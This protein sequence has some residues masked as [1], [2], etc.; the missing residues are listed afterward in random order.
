MSTITITSTA[1][2][3]IGAITQAD[4]PATLTIDLVTPGPAGPAGPAGPIGP[5]GPQ[6]DPGVGVPSG[7]SEGQILSKVDATD[8][9]TTWIDNY[10]TELRI[11]ARNETGAT[12]SKGTVVYING[13][14]GNKPTLAKALATGDA[15]SA[16]TLGLV[17]ADI[18]NNQNGEVTVRGLLIGVDTSAYAAG[19]Q[20]YLSGTTAG[21]FTSTKP[22]A[23]IHIVYV[24]IVSR[25]HANQGQIE[26]AVQN[27]WELG[28]I[29]D[30]LI[31][32]PTNG[33]VL[34]YDAATDLWKN[35]TDL[36]SGVWGQITGT[37]S[38]QTDL[39]NALNAKAP[40]LNPVF[41]GIVT[42]QGAASKTEIFTSAVKVSNPSLGT[43][44]ALLSQT[45]VGLFNDTGIPSI[46]IT[47]AG[48]L[49]NTHTGNPAP[50]ITFADATVQ[51]TAWLG[52]LA[53]GQLT[54]TLS[55]QTDLQNALDAKA[56]LSGATFT[57]K[58]TATATSTNA[59][60]NAGTVLTTPT[61]LAN[62]DIWIG[63]GLNFKNK[64]GAS[65][66]VL[67]NNTANLVSASTTV[68]PVMTIQQNGTT[69]GVGAVVITNSSPANAVRITQTGNGN[70]L[71][72]ED[73]ASPDATPFAIN[74]DGKVG[75]GV[76]PNA[77]AAL[78]LDANGIRWNS[79]G[80]TVQSL[81]APV[82]ATGIYDKEIPIAING[83]TYRIPCR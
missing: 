53:W 66:Q 12:L 36:N 41:G 43:D 79:G 52:S 24:G 1:F 56:S 67:V 59:G 19:T 20:L 9:N 50:T 68:N 44:F 4:A 25:S 33:Q 16:Q 18:L 22:V 3:T 58:I 37:L 42:N 28:E 15:T 7:G 81:A 78:N 31:T 5:Q 51:T 10:A 72:V 64:D 26:V 48:L 35:Q 74:A 38:S 2:G 63:D 11:V 23:P 61:N 83:T 45:H 27:G 57:G 65:R 39:Q 70:A 21:A 32:S 54:G 13:A 8:Y 71:L 75:I 14:S 46:S 77:T 69:S 55:A 17:A 76:A 62:G 6:G 49:L 47:Q 73:S 80:A 82:V 34:K 40:L 30:V 29:H 60:I